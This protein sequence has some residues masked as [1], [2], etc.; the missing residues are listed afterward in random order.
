MR[1]RTIHAITIPAMAPE[2]ND[3]GA[4]CVICDELTPEDVGGDKVDE[5]EGMDDE[6]D[7][8][9]DT[10]DEDEG[11][12]DEEEDT[13]DEEDEDTDEINGLEIVEVDI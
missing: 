12:D 11:T 4:D 3:D 6:D 9:E 10:D 13:D 5:D 8:N 2:F 7:E 1:E